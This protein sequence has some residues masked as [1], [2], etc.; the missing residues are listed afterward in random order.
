LPIVAAAEDFNKIPIINKLL[1]Y[2]GGFYIKRKK[3]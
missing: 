1:K 2:S 3:K